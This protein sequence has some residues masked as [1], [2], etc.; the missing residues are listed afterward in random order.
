MNYFL[1]NVSFNLQVKEFLKSAN[2]WRSYRQKCQMESYA[3]FALDFCP[4]RRRTLRISKISCLLRTET[5]TA[6][7]YVNRQI[8]MSLIS[9]NIKLLQ[10]SF[11]LLTD[12]LMLSVTDRLLIM[13][14][15]LLHSLSLC[16]SSCIQ[17]IMGFL[18][19]WFKQLIVS[20]LSNKYFTRQIL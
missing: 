1:K 6:C 2:M 19:G 17:S 13:Y 9:T 7:S 3:T 8:N 12:R 4:L 5:V 15:I 11:D 10:T 14:G 16:Y 20:E 18:H